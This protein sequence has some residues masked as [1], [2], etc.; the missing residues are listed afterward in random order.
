MSQKNAEIIKLIYIKIN[1]F[2]KNPNFHQRYY[3]LTNIMYFYASACI[4]VFSAMGIF[5][6]QNLCWERICMLTLS[7]YTIGSW[8]CI[9]YSMP[10]AKKKKKSLDTTTQTWFN[11]CQKWTTIEFQNKGFLGLWYLG[12]IYSFIFSI[13]FY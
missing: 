4:C 10:I 6:M 1:N 3:H 11:E 8:L 5:H 7:L 9:L 13:Y 12:F 2:V